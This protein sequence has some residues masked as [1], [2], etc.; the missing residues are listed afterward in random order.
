MT[1]P[2][3]KNPS[4]ARSP[5]SPVNPGSPKLRL[6]IVY[7]DRI[8]F[9]FGR[10]EIL[11]LVDEKGS[12]SAAAAELGMSYR[13]LWGYFRE[14]EEASG[15]KLLVRQRGSGPEAGTHL[16]SAGRAFVDRYCQFHRAIDAAVIREFTRIYK[17]RTAPRSSPA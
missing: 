14:L 9:G 13:N 1:A 16:S 17:R 7:G 10:A 11:R 2:A 5:L 15:A 12:I 6:W 8:K 4:R 3:R